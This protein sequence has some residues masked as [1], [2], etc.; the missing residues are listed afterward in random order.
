[1]V[2]YADIRRYQNRGLA[3]RARRFVRKT[4]LD[5]VSALSDE[6]ALERPRVQ[7][8]FLHHVMA[9][10]ERPFRAL[11]ERLLRRHTFLPYSDA[12]TRVISGDI[13]RP[14]IS[15]T[16]DDGL[17]SQL[18]A[19][20]ILRE[21]GISACFFVSEG[22]LEGHSDAE[23]AE[24]CA[25]ELGLP[26]LELLTWSDVEQLAAVGHEIG[27]HG[28][29]H[30]VLSSLSSSELA[31]EIAGALESLRR[32]LGKVDHFAWPRGWADAFSAA[33][34]E[35]VFRAGHSSCASAIRGCH[36]PGPMRDQRDV[37]LRRDPVIAA[38]PL[39]HTMYFL[40][41]NSLSATDATRDWP[42]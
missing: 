27:N 6:R 3:L 33:A 30:R 34:A 38:D 41:K 13:D 9:D 4:V 21:Y 14:Y 42:W 12:A 19:A 37:C 39:R 24:F 18:R 15:I 17:R 8:L 32:R 1:M 20:E 35:E 2:T 5:F 31:D 40:S 7:I 22:M 29:L 36:V 26:P 25:R 16:F 28:R 23:V 10:E 11:I